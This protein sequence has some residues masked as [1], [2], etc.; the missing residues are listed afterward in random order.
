MPLYMPVIIDALV[1]KRIECFPGMVLLELKAPETARLASPGQ[2]VMIRVPGGGTDPLLRRPFSICGVNHNSIWL[3]IQ[4]KGIGTERI[5]AAKEG[6]TL[7]ILGPLGHG[8]SIDGTINKA[9][10]VA[11]GIGIAPLL[12]FANYIRQH[13]SSC[14][15][16][17]FVGAHTST[18]QNVLDH[19]PIIQNCYELATEDGSA[20][21]KC[22]VTDLVDSYL[23]NYHS[24]TSHGLCIY[25]CGP[26]QML[27]V[28]A[29]QSRAYNVPCQVSYEAPMACGVGAC[30]GCSVLD[31]D[32]VLRR[33]CS[34]GPVFESRIFL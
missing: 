20:G 13:F 5:C 19:F 3:L 21:Q 18:I 1:I 4:I 30:M 16:K 10:L 24:V 15:I 26:P 33:V 34:E 9:L 17:L 29:L 32:G 2:F 8:F 27:D 23:R 25:G 22:M 14:T 11:G 31:R 7:N 12:F 28:L 6:Q